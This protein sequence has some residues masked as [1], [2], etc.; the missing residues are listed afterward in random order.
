M[1][2]IQVGSRQ[3]NAALTKHLPKVVHDMSAELATHDLTSSARRTLG[4]DSLLR[5]TSRRS[6]ENVVG[7]QIRFSIATPR[8]EPVEMLAALGVGSKEMRGVVIDTTIQ[9]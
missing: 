8:S 1:D 7:H 9:T 4:V 3:W 2:E 5:V 6:S